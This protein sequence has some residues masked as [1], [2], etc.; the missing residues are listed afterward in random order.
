MAMSAT[1]CQ[2]FESVALPA[3]CDVA[4]RDERWSPLGETTS[5]QV[6]SLWAIKLPI[7]SLAAW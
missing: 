6:E 3:R 1:P 4:V 7:L 5:F 2:R